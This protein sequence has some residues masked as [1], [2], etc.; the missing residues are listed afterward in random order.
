MTSIKYFAHARNSEIKT[1]A[2]PKF[3]KSHWTFWAEYFQK[4]WQG[5]VH[6]VD[7]IL[8]TP[9]KNFLLL[10]TPRIDGTVCPASNTT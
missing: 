3:P 6:I 8:S 7:G 10:K 5:Q 4:L 1:T 9:S 2:L